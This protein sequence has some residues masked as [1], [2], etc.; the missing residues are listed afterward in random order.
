MVRTVRMHRQYELSHG[1]YD[2]DWL[3]CGSVHVEDNCSG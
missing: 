3:D 2:R 1:G